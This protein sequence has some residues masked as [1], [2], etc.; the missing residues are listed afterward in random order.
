M[1]KCNATATA[2]PMNTCK[3]LRK[4]KVIDSTV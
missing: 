1:G 2:R 3:D 4:C